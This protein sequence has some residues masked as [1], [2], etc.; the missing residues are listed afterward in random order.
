VITSLPINPGDDMS[1]IVEAYSST[2]GAVYVSDLT[3]NQGT[4]IAVSAPAGTTLIGNNAEWIIERPTVSGSVATLMN[5]VEQ[6]FGNAVVDQNNG[7]D[8][9]AGQG[10]TSTTLYILTMLDNSGNAIATLQSYGLAS[11]VLIDE[12]SAR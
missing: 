12:G 7:V 3:T 6:Y 8:L 2:S 11:F 4:G 9:Y 1:V 5:F 10:S